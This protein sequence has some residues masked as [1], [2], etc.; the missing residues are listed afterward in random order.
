MAQTDLFQIKINIPCA[1]AGCFG[2]RTRLSRAA[3][4]DVDTSFGD[5]GLLI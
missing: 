4:G 1:L 5:A 2:W 3:A